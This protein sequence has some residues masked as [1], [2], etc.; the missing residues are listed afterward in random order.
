MRG[1]ISIVDRGKTTPHNQHH[2]MKIT[3]KEMYSVMVTSL[4]K[5]HKFLT[6]QQLNKFIYFDYQS[7]LELM[8]S[9][10]NY[11]HDLTSIRKYLVDTKVITKNGKV[12]SLV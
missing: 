8:G 9:V 11:Q 4:L 5:K 10:W 6:L 7:E 2:I 1:Y 3:K 12:F